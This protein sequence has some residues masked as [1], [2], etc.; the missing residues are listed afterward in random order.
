MHSF[1]RELGHVACPVAGRFEF[2][3]NCMGARVVSHDL[4][5][6]PPQ[7]D[8]ISNCVADVFLTCLAFLSGLPFPNPGFVFCDDDC[9]R[10]SK[11]VFFRSRASK[12]LLAI[13]F[14][15]AALCFIF[16]SDSE[17][18]LRVFKIQVVI[19]NCQFAG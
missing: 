11:Y 18:P 15:L 3:L 7:N 17:A 6:L 8:P 16:D 9:S 19:G 13:G 12:L 14:Y 5:V 2:V 1:P 4:I 10:L